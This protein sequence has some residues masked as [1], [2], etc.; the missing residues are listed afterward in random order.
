MGLVPDIAKEFYKEVG[1]R[2][3]KKRLERDMSLEEL[4]LEMGLTRMQVHRIEA[5][6]NITLKTLLK[7]S[8]ALEIRPETLLKVKK[9]LKKEDLE[10][11][12]NSSKS[13]RS[14]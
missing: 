12:I 10:K 11:L 6:Y 13:S 1:Q 5:G 8:L 9:K 7:L 14:K 2:V 3:K 4:G